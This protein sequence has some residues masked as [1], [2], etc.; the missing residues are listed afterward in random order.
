MIAS[1][2]PTTPCGSTSLNS[3]AGGTSEVSTFLEEVSGTVATGPPGA[4]EAS[5]VALSE[6][7]PAPTI[8]APA[9]VAVAAPKAPP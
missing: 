3:A 5:F 8:P 1:V 4:L 7:T 2:D 6:A 9:V